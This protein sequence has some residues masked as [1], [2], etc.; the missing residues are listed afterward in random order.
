MKC[1]W[2]ERSSLKKGADGRITAKICPEC[3][4]ELLRIRLYIGVE[5][6]LKLI[7]DN[8]IERFDVIENYNDFLNKPK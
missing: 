8:D 4:L 1:K 5:E 7:K 6:W 2:C 3:K